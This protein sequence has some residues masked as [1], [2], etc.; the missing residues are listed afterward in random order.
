MP[1]ED[2]PAQTTN[3]DT[4]SKKRSRDDEEGDHDEGD[5]QLAKDTPTT[6][7]KKGKMDEI[8]SIERNALIYDE[9]FNVTGHKPDPKQDMCCGKKLAKVDYPKCLTD[10]DFGERRTLRG[11]DSSSCHG[12]PIIPSSDMKAVKF[13]IAFSIR[14]TEGPRRDHYYHCLDCKRDFCPDCAKK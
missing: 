6:A 7:K 1:M 13:M 4:G 3:V 11:C 14:K 8:E 9:Q 10:E 2:A 5:N 12:A